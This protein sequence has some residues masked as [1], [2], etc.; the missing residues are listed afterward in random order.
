M[1]ALAKLMDQAGRASVVGERYESVIHLVGGS[2]AT[3]ELSLQSLRRAGCLDN[4]LPWAILF[5]PN[6]DDPQRVV[7]QP[8]PGPAGVKR[9]HMQQLKRKGESMDRSDENE[10]TGTP[11]E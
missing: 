3:V 2:W 6:R 11:V 5:G 9:E 8:R 4:D 10:K 7:L 1:L